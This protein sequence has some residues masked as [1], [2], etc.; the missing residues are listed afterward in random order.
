MTKQKKITYAFVT[1]LAPTLLLAFST[2][3]D[4]RYTA[5]PGDNPMGCATAGCHTGLV[6]GGPINAGGGAVTATFS[7]GN[8][9]TPGQPV[10]VVVNV[11]DPVNRLHGFQMTARFGNNDAELSVRQ[12]GRFSF[13]SDSGVLVLCDNSVPRSSGGDCPAGF[14]VEFIEHNA[15]RTGAWTFTWTPSATDEGP[16]HF[17]IAGNA[18]NGD[19]RNGPQDHVYTANYVLQPLSSS[20]SQSIPVISEVRRI[21]GWGDG[22]TF[23]S[24]SWLEIKG[25]NLSQST[26][27]WLDSDF[28]GSNAP[29][30]LDGT[31]VSVNGKAGFVEYVSPTQIDLQA[32]ADLATGPVPITVT[33]CA[34]TSNSAAGLNLQKLAAAPGIL[35]PPPEIS[36]LFTRGGKQFGEATFGF[37]FRFVGNDD[38]SIPGLFQPARPG[39][40]LLLYA[41]G[42]G[43]TTP[44]M[45]PGVKAT[46]QE[47]VNAHIEVNFGATPATVT[48]AALYPTFVGLYYL[49][50]T[51]PDVPDG[52]HR[53]NITVDG[54]PLQQEP[55][56]LTVHH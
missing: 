18:V 1:A 20:C 9:F 45:T 50:V 15:P 53:I 21:E 38:P 3:P 34:G 19:G 5:A 48:R 37:E 41:I 24:G 22:A 39:D 43:N 28:N 49:M 23:S 27:Q 16:V 25:T 8:T 54:Q 52:D 35:A 11:T 29:T 14:P 32:P 12:A 56:F 42:L 4:A 40:S 10:T 55:F 33:N 7:T 2:G 51:V 44:A 46:G 17:Y 36:P 47:L 30:S 26:R 31:S 13:T 6:K